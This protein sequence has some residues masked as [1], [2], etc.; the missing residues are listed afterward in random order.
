MPKR[1]KIK[2]EV[3]EIS[4]EKW[5][6]FLQNTDICYGVCTGPSGETAI[7]RTCD[8]LN[9]SLSENKVQVENIEDT[10]EM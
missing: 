6:I 10:G 4:H 1:N 8:R 3:R 2:Y 7:K 5:G 9:R